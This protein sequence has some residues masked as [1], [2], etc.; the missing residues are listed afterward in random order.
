MQLQ[1]VN[2]HILCRVFPSN[3]MGFAKKWYQHIC[4]SLILRFQHLAV[5]FKQRFITCILPKEL[6]SSL[7][8]IRQNPG[9][10]LRSYVDRFNEKANQVKQLNYEIACAKIKNPTRNYY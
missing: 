7:Q 1:N 8:K 2:D 3:L 9:E 6:S 4:P 5:E 10:S